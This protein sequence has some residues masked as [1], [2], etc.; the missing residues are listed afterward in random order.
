M[1]AFALRS[2]REPPALHDLPIPA[3][4]GALPCW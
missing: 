1:R 2:F 4:D 3:A